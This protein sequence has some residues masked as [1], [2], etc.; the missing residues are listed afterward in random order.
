MNR[1]GR[2]AFDGGQWGSKRIF[3]E[4]SEAALHRRNITDNRVSQLRGRRVGI[5]TVT[6]FCM[7]CG[8]AAKLSHWL[9]VSRNNKWWGLG[10]DGG[11]GRYTARIRAFQIRTIPDNWGW[12]TVP[13]RSTSRAF[14]DGL[15]FCFC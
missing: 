12:T 6:G 1:K 7:N 8:A 4:R 11:W 5:V 2:R 14:S 3:T 15:C 13:L 9:K 10:W